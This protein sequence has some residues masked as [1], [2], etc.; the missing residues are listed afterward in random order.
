MAFTWAAKRQFTILLILAI[1]ASIGL[2]I[3]FFPIIFAAPSCNDNRQNGD[4]VGV[5]CGGSCNRMCSFEVSPPTV[6]WS[7]ALPVTDS[8]YNLVAYVE[9]KNPN[10]GVYEIPYEFRL[11]DATDTFII[12]RAGKTY[13]GP[14]G[15]TAIFE[16]SVQVGNRTPKYAVFEFKGTPVWLK[17]PDTVRNLLVTS[18][19][20]SL[21]NETTSPKLTA[22]IVNQS[23]A[24]LPTV[25]VTG[26]VYNADNNVIG[27]S[28]T[29]IPS[30]GPNATV[31][32]VFTWPQA[33]S[34]PVHFSDV[35]VR[36]NPFTVSL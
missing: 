21:T 20:I 17:V 5:D 22:T 12:A 34:E 24:T 13:I 15:R 35:V 1:V 9:N 26:L 31:P 32:I 36:F 10:A 27:V 4:E 6:L 11:Y 23:L 8:V 2:F 33:F 14:N 16:P 18:S 7:R 28:R 3:F 19:N 29:F 25:E 30:L